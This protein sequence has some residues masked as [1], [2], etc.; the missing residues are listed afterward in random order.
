LEA[1]KQL[2]RQCVGKALAAR[3]ANLNNGNENRNENGNQ[4]ETICVD[5]AYGMSWK[6]L[7]KLMIEQP[8]FKRHDVVRAYTAGTNKKRAYA[9]TLPYCN[10]CKLHHTGQC[11]VKCGNCRKVGHMT[12]DCKAP[13]AATNQRAPMTRNKEARERVYAIGGGEINPDSNVVTCTFLLN[14]LYASILFNSELGS[15]DVIIGMDWLSKYHAIIICD[16]KVVRIPYDNEVLTIP[17]D[18]SDGGS[19]AGYY[20]RFIEGFSKI[21]KPMPKLTQK[22]MKFD[23]G[24]K[25]E[26]AF[27][28]LKK[29]LCSADVS[30]CGCNLCS[31][32]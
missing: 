16:E 3:E 21:A 15:F 20:R 18:R 27:Q 4:N 6:D 13:V 1:I 29:K 19:L 10:K 23:W 24:E 31:K 25:E 9:G 22:G 14:N 26:E 28:L 30:L 8:P 32:F 2:I 17:G 12:R 7:M 5:E 11:I